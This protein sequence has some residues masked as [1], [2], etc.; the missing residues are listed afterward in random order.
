MK[1]ISGPFLYVGGAKIFAQILSRLFPF[2]RGL[3]HAYWAPNLWA[4]YN[5]VDLGLYRT[6]KVLNKLP[7][8]VQ[9]PQYTT[10]L[11]QVCHLLFYDILVNL[12]W[13]F[14]NVILTMLQQH[15]YDPEGVYFEDN[16]I[17]R[18][19]FY[20]ITF[21]GFFV[22]RNLIRRDGKFSDMYR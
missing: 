1:W 12:F 17:S 19:W 16:F 5:F 9:P 4:I 15:L 14:R 2:Q 21:R 22:G 13:P 18:G 11:V 10:G 3:T 20:E 8:N 7:S 6:L